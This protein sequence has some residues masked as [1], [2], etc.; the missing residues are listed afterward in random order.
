M[1][2]YLVNFRDAEVFVKN[3][4]AVKMVLLLGLL[5]PGYVLCSTEQ[6]GTYGDAIRLKLGSGFS[7]MLFGIAEVPKNIINTSNQANVLLGVSGGTLKG[8]LHSVGRML[9][10]VTDVLTFPAATKPI[11]TPAF[12]WQDFA[13]DTSYGPFFSAV[14]IAPEDSRAVR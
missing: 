12:V 11:T 13:T 1:N 10:G 2:I 4:I 7:N 8:V 14:R 5:S 9:S 3:G 6:G